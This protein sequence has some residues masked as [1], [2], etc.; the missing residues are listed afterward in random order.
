MLP[1]T[2]ALQIALLSGHTITIDAAVDETVD[3]LRQRAQ[4]KLQRGLR[5]LVNPSGLVLQK[6]HTL[7]DAGIK[8]GDLLT[9]T[10]EPIKIVSSRFAAAFAMI[11][12]DGSVITWGN[13]LR[14]GDSNAPKDEDATR[15]GHSRHIQCVCCTD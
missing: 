10:A 4:N 7:Q 6:C 1:G 2:I 14:G 3:E 11:T 13:A 9:A 5:C 15:S 12:F 8:S